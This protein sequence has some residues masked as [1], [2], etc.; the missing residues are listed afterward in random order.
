MASCL[1]RHLSYSYYANLIDGLP[2][3]RYIDSITMTAITTPPIQVRKL[4]KSFASVTAVDDISFDVAPGAICALLGD[5]GAGKT[6]T[7]AMLLGLLTPTSG[8]ITV[9]GVDMLRDRYRALPRLNFSSP[10]VDLPKRLTVEEN[11]TVYARL[12]GLRDVRG[13]LRQ[14]AAD[15]DI[16]DFLSRPYGMLSSG[17]RTRVTV[18]KA[19]LNEP[20]VLFLDEP[21]A[22]LDPDTADR[23]RGYLESYRQQSGATLLLASHNMYEVERLCDDVIMLQQGRI[24][25][26]GP[27]AAL[28]QRYN[29]KTMEEVFLTIARHDRSRVAGRREV[30][31]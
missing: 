25:A 13:R 27:P 15:L 28:L 20:Q 17:Q 10:Y 1:T 6:T 26:H 18:A 9:L 4:C 16:G 8:S 21:T 5:N 19:L 22:S 11:L 7:L 12:Y 29:S 23:I 31:P 2:S 14:L 3:R 24:V 30:I